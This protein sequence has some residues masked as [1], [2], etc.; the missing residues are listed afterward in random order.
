[1]SYCEQKLRRTINSGNRKLPPTLL[2]LHAARVLGKIMLPVTTM[3][4]VSYEFEVDSSTTCEE[5]L[6]NLKNK[7]GLKSI[8]GFSVYARQ[9]DQVMI[10]S[11]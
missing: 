1:M 3:D 4:A 8:F 2:E 9:F 7:L 11:F 10:F 6:N 5:L